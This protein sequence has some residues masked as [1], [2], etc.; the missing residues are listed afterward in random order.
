MPKDNL[1]MSAL[2]GVFKSR[3]NLTRIELCRRTARARQTN[4]RHQGE[5]QHH[6][7]LAR[8]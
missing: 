5:Q 1:Q 3:I 7:E 6:Q 4:H 2:N 8:C